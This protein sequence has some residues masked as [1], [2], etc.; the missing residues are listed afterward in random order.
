MSYRARIFT[1]VAPINHIRLDYT[2]YIIA[3]QEVLHNKLPF[4]I[5]I[6]KS[7]ITRMLYV[8]Y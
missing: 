2:L 1:L 4:R 7:R 3:Q 8:T 6:P 5:Y